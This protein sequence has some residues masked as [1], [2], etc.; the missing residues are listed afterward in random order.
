M[1]KIKIKATITTRSQAHS[2]T[3]MFPI[4]NSQP[5]RCSNVNTFNKQDDTLTV[6]FTSN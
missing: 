3:L 1:K 5:K 6:G 2:N 4:A